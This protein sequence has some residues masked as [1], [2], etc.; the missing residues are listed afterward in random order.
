M[1]RHVYSFLYHV[2][3]GALRLWHPIFRVKGRENIP[4]EG[5]FVI[6]ANHR[7]MMDPVW[8]LFGMKATK[9][10]PHIMAKA[11]IMKIPIIAP[12]LKSAG[13]F[14]VRRGENDINAVKNGLSTLKNGKNL[15]LF[16]EGTRVKPGKTV[17]AKPGAVLLAMRTGTPILPAYLETK[18]WPFSPM[19]CVFGAP[20]IPQAENL[21]RPTPEE[22]QCRSRELM[23]TIY[24]LGETK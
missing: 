17:E 15:M 24:A 14:G 4:T 7:G 1:N 9:G 12:I 11:S 20:Y 23:E 2:L 18:R 6:C 22:L 19:R 13:V 16:P 3:H 5:N 8:L 21:R 10:C